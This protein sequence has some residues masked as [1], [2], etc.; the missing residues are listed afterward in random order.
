MEMKMT[1]FTN[2]SPNP[3]IL[4]APTTPFTAIAVNDPPLTVETIKITLLPSYIYSY[5]SDGNLSWSDPET[6]SPDVGSISDPTPGATG[7]MWNQATHTFTE[8]VAVTGTPTEGTKVLQRLV[9][10]P[11]TLTAG[12]S[13]LVSAVVSV[14][15]ANVVGANPT[16]PPGGTGAVITPNGSVLLETVTSPAVLGTIQNIPVAAPTPTTPTNVRPFATVQV[17][18]NNFQGSPQLGATIVVTDG[19]T[20]TD[21]DGLL[22]G[23]GVS[24]VGV[25]T[26]TLSS[27]SGYGLTSL[28]QGLTF[29]P[30]AT[31]GTDRTT[32]FDLSVTDNGFPEL[33]TDDKNTSV[34]VQTGQSGPL[35]AG[36]GG[37]GIT[38]VPGTIIQPFQNVTISD[39]DPTQT[40]SATIA[41]NVPGGGVLSGPGVAVNSPTQYTIPATSPA[42]LTTILRNISFEPSTPGDPS[43]TSSTIALNVSDATGKTTSGSIPIIEVSGSTSTGPGSGP[44]GNNNP[45]GGTNPPA[46]ANFSTTDVTTSQTTTTSGDAYSGPVAGLSHELIQITADSL[47]VTANIPNVF[48]KTGSGT[49]AINVSQVGGTNVLDGSTGSNFLTGGSGGDTFYLDDRAPATDV[50]STVVGFHPGDNASVFGVNATD[51]ALNEL[52]GQGAAGF[53]GLDFAFSAPNHAN[54]NIVLAGYSTADLSNGR[55]AVTYGTTSDGTQYMNVHAN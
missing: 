50:F 48:I 29:T 6:S 43:S 9:Y 27:T 47:N 18:D 36:I 46:A 1:T 44:G 16:P 22:T 11:P 55:L 10:T 42:A 41:I 25:G 26:Y 53:T 14:N 12:S 23:T 7:A 4:S 24:K 17:T 21:A 5:F 2:G 3:T 38:V 33:T 34:L 31:S 39:A 51:F 37:V 54:A 45:P 15:G 19:G 30:T 49:D 28:L 13:D 52:N 35:V 8:Q 40:V 32:S 20:A